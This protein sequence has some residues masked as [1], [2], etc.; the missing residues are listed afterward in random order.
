[1]NQLCSDGCVKVI[2]FG[3]CM[4]CIVMVFHFGEEQNNLCN[5]GISTVILMKQI[6]ISNEFFSKL[7]SNEICTDA[8]SIAL[9]WI[10]N[11]TN[12]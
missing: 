4:E 12:Q 8:Y 6:R 7:A 10:W 9:I 2:S 3:H 5:H 11:Q 1:M